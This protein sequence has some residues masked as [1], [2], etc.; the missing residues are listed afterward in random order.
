MTCVIIECPAPVYCLC[1]TKNILYFPVL[2]FYFVEGCWPSFVKTKDCHL[3]VVT[4]KCIIGYHIKYVVIKDAISKDRKIIEIHFSIS[5]YLW[6]FCLS[7]LLSKVII[8]TFTY[9]KYYLH[10]KN[11]DH[12]HMNK[13]ILTTN[14]ANSFT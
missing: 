4:L 11:L 12:L 8:S 10:W 9:G 13:C 5:M 6:F 3:E 7:K 14:W 2:K 1:Y